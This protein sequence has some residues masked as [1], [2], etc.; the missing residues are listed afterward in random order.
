LRTDKGGRNELFL[1]RLVGL[2]FPVILGVKFYASMQIEMPE[3][4]LLSFPTGIASI[5][6]D[7]IRER[8]KLLTIIVQ[9]IFSLSVIFW[10]LIG[11]HNYH[12]ALLKLW[13]YFLSF[14]V[15]YR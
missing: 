5:I 11:H 9:R 2:G 13:S 10:L 8:L 15:G 6:A 12:D 4:F 1:L 14:E 7:S 3:I